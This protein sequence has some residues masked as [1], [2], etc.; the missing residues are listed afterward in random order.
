MTAEV[1]KSIRRDPIWL[2]TKLRRL[3]SEKRY[4]PEKLSDEKDFLKTYR[5]SKG[6]M[7]EALKSRKFKD[8]STSR[9]PGGGASVARVSAEKTNEL[10]WIYFF[11]ETC[12]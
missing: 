4:L 7:R 2:L 11:Q 10:F 8:S 9:W 12:P 5:V 1:P 6:P 3:L